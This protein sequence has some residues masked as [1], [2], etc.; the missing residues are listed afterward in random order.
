[1]YGDFEMWLN[2]LFGGDVLLPTSANVLFDLRH[3]NTGHYKLYFVAV[4]DYAEMGSPQNEYWP[5]MDDDLQWDVILEKE[6]MLEEV[7]SLLK[8]Y[9]EKGL[10][11]GKLKSY[12]SVSIGWCMS[13][14]QTV[15]QK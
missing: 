12:Q 13:V 7:S 3:V 9:L 15:H 6:E 4:R 10:F 14:C 2:R 5:Y 1:M 8:E 11:S